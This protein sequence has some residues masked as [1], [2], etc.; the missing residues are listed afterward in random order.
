M[1]DVVSTE[2]TASELLDL[3][4][5]LPVSLNLDD[6]TALAELDGAALA[7]LVRREVLAASPETIRRIAHALD[8][9]PGDSWFFWGPSIEVTVS[10]MEISIS[11][12][13]EHLVTRTLVTRTRAN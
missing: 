13:R 3:L 8:Q 11:C 5:D 10:E 9:R 1:P 2:L 6:L 7:G 4:A 12:E